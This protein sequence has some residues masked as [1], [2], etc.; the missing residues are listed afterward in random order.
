MIS[1]ID[2]G[3][4]SDKIQQTLVIINAQHYNSLESCD[5]EG[6]GREVQE[7]GALYTPMVASCRCMAETNT[8]L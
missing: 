6:G 1:P 5:G 2:I 8:I 4:K 3:K 7:G